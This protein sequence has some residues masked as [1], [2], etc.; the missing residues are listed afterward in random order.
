MELLNIG[1]WTEVFLAR[2][3]KK[4]RFPDGDYVLKTVRREARSPKQALELLHCEAVV[5]RSVQHPHLVPV[6]GADLFLPTPYL[7]MP[8]LQGSDL[9][10][11]LCAGKTFS[12]PLA[13]W[14]ARQTAS[15]LSAL[16]AA[17]WVHGD[18]KPANIHWTSHGHVTLLDY[19]FC[20]PVTPRWHRK[21][22]GN[23][24]I[25]GSPAYL[26]PEFFYAEATP[27]TGVDVYALGVTLFQILTGRLPFQELSRQDLLRLRRH[28]D[29]PHPCDYRSDIPA[30]VADFTLGL[31]E[32]NALR[33]RSSM[34]DVQ[35]E[36]ARLEIR[37]LEHCVSGQ[38]GKL[39][40]VSA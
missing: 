32:K 13:L 38:T 18:V 19:G 23:S 11:A 36:L 24:R 12:V 8:Y 30:E 9:S 17:G 1:E 27:W 40:P 29:P 28:L 31:L 22:R 10:K 33:R 39:M 15:G 5:A 25:V 16:H 2:P 34:D 26:A 21:G 3:T 4:S 20:H 6:F 7:V 35:E 37:Y 14:I